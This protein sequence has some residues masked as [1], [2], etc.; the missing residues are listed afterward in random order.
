MCD[1]KCNKELMYKRKPENPKNLHNAH[2]WHIHTYTRALYVFLQSQSNGPTKCSQK[3]SS[4]TD[5]QRKK[6]PGAEEDVDS[7]TWDAAHTRSLWYI[8]KFSMFMGATRDH[9][10][11]PPTVSLSHSAKSYDRTQNALD[12]NQ[13][14]FPLTFPPLATRSSRLLYLDFSFSF[15]FLFLYK[16]KISFSCS[17]PSAKKQALALHKNWNCAQCSEG[18]TL[19]LRIC[20]V[21]RISCKFTL[22]RYMLRYSIH[23]IYA[24]FFP[25]PHLSIDMHILSI[26]SWCV[27]VGNDA[28]CIYIRFEMKSCNWSNWLCY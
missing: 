24:L 1:E 7:V 23:S 17:L 19:L 4:S 21:K 16:K 13:A 2:N 6:S 14:R 8:D 10:G 27:S 12:F 9:T 25:S 18:I 20:L 11:C 26:S 22:I 28:L 5:T 3:V 15:Q